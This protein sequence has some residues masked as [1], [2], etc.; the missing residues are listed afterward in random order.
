LGEEVKEKSCKKEIRKLIVETAHQLFIEH[1]IKDVKMDDIATKL[2]ISK[3]T[4][5]ELFND[6]E[7]LLREILELQNE[8]M[9]E[10]GK[11]IIR[12]SKHILEIILK[13]YNLHFELLKKVNGKFFAELSKYPEICKESRKKKRKTQ[14]NSAPGWSWGDSK[15]CSERMPTLKSLYS[16]SSEILLQSL[17]QRCRPDTPTSRNTLP[18]NWVEN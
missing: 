5:Y 18:T 11:E 16:S 15:D 2:S 12:N 1:G 10:N 9:L 17:R 4:I 6:K 3:R 8:K 14:R 13:L 7:Q